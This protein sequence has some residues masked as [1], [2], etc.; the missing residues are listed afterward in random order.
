MTLQTAGAIAGLRFAMDETGGLVCLGCQQA[1]PSVERFARHA[2]RCP[3]APGAV[4]VPATT[5]TT[6]LEAPGAPTGRPA[7][8]E[9]LPPGY[10]YVGK[11]ARG[12]YGTVKA[13]DGRQLEG[14]DNG[15]FHGRRD[16]A[17]AAWK[18][19]GA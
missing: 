12:G 2:V 5:P 10:A 8:P 17:D 13:P 18:D 4:L 7:N 1:Y 3:R 16:A 11:W 9:E 6:V 15:K 14:P 19:Y